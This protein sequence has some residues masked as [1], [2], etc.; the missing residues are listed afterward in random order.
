MAGSRGAREADK[1]MRLGGAK[2][3]SCRAGAQF[4]SGPSDIFGMFGFDKLMMLEM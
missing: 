4:R 3:G 1:V 2:N